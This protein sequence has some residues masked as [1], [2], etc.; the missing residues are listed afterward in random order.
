MIVA[1]GMPHLHRPADPRDLGLPIVR[2]TF[3]TN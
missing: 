2:V 1:V 3:E